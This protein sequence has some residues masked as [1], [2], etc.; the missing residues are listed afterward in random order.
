MAVN[1]NFLEA[2]S[3]FWSF[4]AFCLMFTNY[5]CIEFKIPRLWLKDHRTSQHANLCGVLQKGA[6][7]RKKS[8]PTR[9]GYAPN[10]IVP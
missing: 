5:P 10:A 7:C 6:G 4:F 1:T 8:N 2:V 9:V 3:C